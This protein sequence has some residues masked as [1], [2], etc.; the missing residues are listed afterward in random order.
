MARIANRIHANGQA[1]DLSRIRPAWKR[2][3][4]SGWLREKLGLSE[5]ELKQYAEFILNVAKER[6]EQ[7]P[8]TPSDE[9][10]DK[11]FKEM[12]EELDRN[13]LRFPEMWDDYDDGDESTFPRTILR[14]PARADEIARVESKLGCALPDDLKQFYALTNGTQPVISGP[15]FYRLNNPL[16]SVFELR[17]EDLSWN[18]CYEFDLFPEMSLPVHVVWPTFEGGAVMMYEDN[19]Q[20]TKYMW[21]FQGE[22]LA[23]AKKALE[24]T[25]QKAGELEKKRID[26]AVEQFHGSWE[27]LRDLQSCWYQAAWGY[28]PTALFH[29]FRDFF[30]LV[31]FQSRYEEDKSPLSLPEGE[32]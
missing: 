12:L 11:S 26:K 21:Y 13:T 32:T 9:Y 7:G 28:G 6:L 24:E 14:A 22:L 16:L 18:G 27:K 31:V 8:V 2:Y 30:S 20:R 15:H 29:T 25:Y 23:K 17:W 1:R 5:D 19:G 4:A 10:K 3:F